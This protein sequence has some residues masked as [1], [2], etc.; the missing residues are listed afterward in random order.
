MEQMPSFHRG[1][2]PTLGH[3]AGVSNNEAKP[4]G[5]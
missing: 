1:A 4:R 3:S 2:L 5:R